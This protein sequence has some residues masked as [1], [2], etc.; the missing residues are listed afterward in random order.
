MTLESSADYSTFYANSI[1]SFPLSR[2]EWPSNEEE[3]DIILSIL[4]IDTLPLPIQNFNKGEV[5][6]RVNVSIVND[7]INYSVS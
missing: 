3:E 5:M 4:Y 1:P 2:Y 6:L 7:L